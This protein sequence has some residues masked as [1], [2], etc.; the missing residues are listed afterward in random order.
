MI[1]RVAAMSAAAVVV[2]LA[3]QVLTHERAPSEQPAL[4]SPPRLALPADETRASQSSPAPASAPVERALD[5]A[6]ATEIVDTPLPAADAPLAIA[7]APLADPAFGDGSWRRFIFDC[8]NGVIFAVRVVQG[9]AALISPQA[10]GAEIIWLPQVDASGARYAENGVSFSRQGGLATFEI[11]ERTFADCTSNPGAAETAEARRRRATF[12]AH[13]N[14]P[15][16]LLAI[17]PDSIDLAKDVG[18]G[19][20]QFPYRAPTVA[21]T[22][23]TY[24]SFVGTQEL[25]VFIDAIPCHDTLSGE[26]FEATVTVTVE[27]MTLYGCGRAP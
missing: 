19:R 12:F 5:P 1:K 2:V 27:G 10:L 6:A 14:G 26:R 24:R 25:L 7:D 11:R 4:D 8:G 21:S 3:V 16:W 17:S 18:T 20:A 23:T 22:R 13:G 9:E 15:T